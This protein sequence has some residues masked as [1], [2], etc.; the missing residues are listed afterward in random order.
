M[1]L[2]SK[3]KQILDKFNVPRDLQDW[4]SQ[5]FNE[6]GE[7]ITPDAP[8]FLMAISDHLQAAETHLESQRIKLNQAQNPSRE[9]HAGPEEWQIL[10]TSYEEAVKDAWLRATGYWRIIDELL[11]KPDNYGVKLKRQHIDYAFQK[12][13]LPLVEMLKWNKPEYFF[14]PKPFWIVRYWS[15]LWAGLGGIFSGIWG[16][17]SWAKKDS[18]KQKSFLRPLVFLMLALPGI[19]IGSMMGAITSASLGYRTG[20]IMKSIKIGYYAAAFNP[21]LKTP[22]S[23]SKQALDLKIEETFFCL[24]TEINKAQLDQ[25][26]LDHHFFI[27]FA[28][29]QDVDCILNFIKE[30]AAHEKMLSEVVA[31]PKS[32]RETLFGPKANAKVI[33]G[34][35]K[36]EPVACLIFFHNYHSVLAKTGIFIEDLYIKKSSRGYGL[37]QRMLAFLADLALKQDC[38]RI[39]WQVSTRNKSAG[40]FYQK[41]GAKPMKNWVVYSMEGEDLKKLAWTTL[42]NRQSNL[43]SNLR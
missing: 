26:D 17:L 15:G 7:P 42:Y 11:S 33:L 16:G 22:A 3:Q 29:E 2:S 6:H 27:R 36:G 9:A 35:L 10:L 5:E 14:V 4:M 37:G 39:D 19:V 28:T 8:D 1:A 13:N 20:K 38:Q 23:K 31:T 12:K 21:F 24:S 41:L 25:Q 30:L 32:L 18:S 43:D 40:K 34:F